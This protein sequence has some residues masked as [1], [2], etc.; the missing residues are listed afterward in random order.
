MTN[1]NPLCPTCTG[2]IS[3]VSDTGDALRCPKCRTRFEVRDDE[4]ST[5]FEPE[6]SQDSTCDQ[7]EDS[8]DGTIEETL[9]STLD[10]QSQSGVPQSSPSRPSSQLDAHPMPFS[11]AFC[12]QY[13]PVDFLGKGAMGEVYLMRQVKLNRLVAV[14]VVKKEAVSGEVTAR[15]I[16]EAQTLASLNHSN[17]LAIYDVGQ[18]GE[19][20][21]M[22]S[23][24]VEGE[25]LNERLKREP[26]LSLQQSLRIVINVLDG[27]RAAHKQSIIHRDLKPSNIFLAANGKPKIGDFGLAK[28]QNAPSGTAVGR[29]LGTPAYM[30][31]EQ[32]R[33]RTVSPQSDIYAM[34]VML[35][36]LTTGERPFTG[37]ALLDYLRQHTIDPAPRAR[38]LNPDI[39]P[40]LDSAIAKAMEK[41]PAAR[42]RNATEFRKVVLDVSRSLSNQPKYE[43]IRMADGAVSQLGSELREGMVLA[44]RYQLVRI[45]GAGGMGQVW[46]AKDEIR[47]GVE[48]AIKL[49]PPELWRDA[50]ARAN[51]VNEANIALRLTHRDIVRLINIEPGDSPFLVME[52]VVG[53]TL[54]EELYRRRQEILG[55]LTPQE[56]LDVLEPV[57]RALDYAHDIDVVHRDVKPSNILLLM[58]GNHVR[59]AKLADFGIAAEVAGLRQRL[60][61]AAPLGTLA[62]MSPEQLRS[63][64]LDGRADVYSLAATVYQ[65]LSGNPPFGGPDIVQRI[66]EEP[67]PELEGVSPNVAHVL[68]RGLAKNRTDRPTRASDFVA[69]LKAAVFDDS[70]IATTFRQHP[71]DHEDTEDTALEHAGGATSKTDTA[72]GRP[73]LDGGP[74]VNPP[75]LAPSG[76][77][78]T[79]PAANS[80]WFPSGVTLAIA[81]CAFTLAISFAYPRWQEIAGVVPRPSSSIAAGPDLPL[82]GASSTIEPPSSPAPTLN[83]S[84]GASLA[85]PAAKGRLVVQGVEPGRPLQTHLGVDVGQTPGPIE[86]EPGEHLLVVK[87]GPNFEEDRRKIT[88]VSGRQE[89][90][91]VFLQ[92]RVVKLQVQT[93]PPG[94]DV[95]VNDEPRGKA[96]LEVTI[97]AGRETRIAASLA[98]FETESERLQVNAGEVR[99]VR[100]KLRAADVLV[101]VQSTPGGAKVFNEA[102][103]ELGVTPWTTKVPP[104]TSVRY[105]LTIDGHVPGRVEGRTEAGKPLVLSQ[106]L[107]PVEQLAQ[108]APPPKLARALSDREQAELDRLLGEARDSLRSGEYAKALDRARQALELDSDRSE[109]HRYIGACYVA[110]QQL[111][112]AVKALERAVELNPSDTDTRNTLANVLLRLDQADRALVIARKNVEIQQNDATFWDTLGQALLALKNNT[113]AAEA[114]KKA[115]RLDPTY[116]ASIEGLAK[117]KKGDR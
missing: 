29:L 86:L 85:K 116:K 15:L 9:D 75:P 93:I 49:L 102:G 45:L 99:T 2:Q 87:P 35:Y 19:T 28:S 100:L 51:L 59:T 106:Q 82:P 24:Y 60:T 44:K 40:A 79:S 36:E 27:L 73:A 83:P 115:L 89:T 76:S 53:P 22:V 81:L 52:A 34:G 117:C 37:P 113:E 4:Q 16:K 25:P 46:L 98:G 50:E 88:I 17:I 101:T 104:G 70:G 96:P 109:T 3:L 94:A 32:C 71:R 69:E 57:A 63:E 84:P 61:G 7:A 108:S 10:V 103:L 77:T 114:F 78:S 39:P 21:Y 65:M 110:Q 66:K 107:R 13:E 95:A 67:P 55:P 91:Q 48:I 41:D 42:F 43:P 111:G 58:D 92:P 112:R 31:P 6:N 12:A 14:K 64:K 30:S 62:Y 97:L 20:P 33:G 1:S 74:A 105:T 80:R 72:K 54:A 5:H 47:A 38:A 90:W 8:R 56:C 18:D 68:R 11:E 23:E 26:P